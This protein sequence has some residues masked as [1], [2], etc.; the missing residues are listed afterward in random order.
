M[1]PADSVS[2][3]EYR[4][5]PQG[6]TNNL[7]SKIIKVEEG[8]RRKRSRA[9][10]DGLG[11]AVS[12]IVANAAAAHLIS[13]N[14]TV[15]IRL[16]KNYYSSPPQYRN[17]SLTHTY[18][19][20]AFEGLVSLGYLKR[21]KKGHYDRVRKSGETTRYSATEKLMS[22]F[23]ESDLN[24]LLFN[25][26]NPEAETIILR[27]R[28]EDRRT[29]IPF[30]HTNQTQEFKDNLRRINQCL[31][32]YWFDLYITDEEFMRLAERVRDDP[33]KQPFDPSQRTLRRIFSEGNR[34]F[35]RGGRFYGAW[36]QHVPSGYRKYIHIDGKQTVEYDFGQIHPTIMY[37]RT[38]TT[39]E[40]D[41]YDIGLPADY[42]PVVKEAFNA[43]VQAPTQLTRKP[44]EI[45]LSSVD[46][47]WLELRRLILDRHQPIADQFFRGDG[48]Q[49]QFLDSRVAELVMLQFAKDDIPCLPV[50]DSFIM[51]HGY[52]DELKGF[53]RAAFKVVTF[54]A[55]VK[56]DLEERVAPPTDG[57]KLES[58][59]LEDLLKGGSDYSIYD[60]RLRAFRQWQSKN[61]LTT[62][63]D[64]GELLD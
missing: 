28:V 19:K 27:E 1:K 57:L 3:K 24:N 59:T 63:D 22:L 46:L 25:A 6:I 15:G 23:S 38:E 61:K 2:L 45:D 4:K 48:N 9:D 53:M 47:K 31:S 36:W 8:V 11:F 52:A 32:G 60:K 33:K 26:Y 35:D 44:L 20:S 12:A 17:A 5:S 29:N 37:S 14:R 16:H 10:R 13:T 64:A 58:S 62:G 40:G 54:N 41:A 56:I 34:N 49:L 18:M 42:R 43:M 55:E 21:N 7:V 30:E 50:H 39:C 51:H